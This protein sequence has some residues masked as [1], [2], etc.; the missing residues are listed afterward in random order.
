M[1]EIVTSSQ[2]GFD[3]VIGVEMAQM[4]AALRELPVLIMTMVQSLA[5]KVI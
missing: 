5:E 2:A 4:A 3:V 1:Q